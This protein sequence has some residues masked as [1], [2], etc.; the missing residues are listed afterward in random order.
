MPL[1]S[2]SHGHFASVVTSASHVGITHGL[3]ML[4]NKDLGSQK[5]LCVCAPGVAV[6][7]EAVCRWRWQAGPVAVAG[8][9]FGGWEPGRVRE[10]L[11]AVGPGAF[12]HPRAG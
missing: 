9:A 11:P 5:P 12:R 2:W 1:E 10:V 6:K 4:E 8:H 3:R 7:K